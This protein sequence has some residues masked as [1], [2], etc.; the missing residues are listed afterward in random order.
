[1]M[2]NLPASSSSGMAAGSLCRP[3]PQPP[4]VEIIGDT[5]RGQFI[6]KYGVMNYERRITR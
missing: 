5:L 2:E 1:M 3:R 4:V 6:D